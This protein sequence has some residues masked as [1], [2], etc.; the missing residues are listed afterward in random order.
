MPIEKLNYLAECK[1]GLGGQTA[2]GDLTGAYL[3]QHS[4]LLIT[5]FTKI[6]EIIRAVNK[7][8]K[9]GEPHDNK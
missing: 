2:L 8:E 6:N 3:N 4:Y 9:Q 5:L 7:S 1:N